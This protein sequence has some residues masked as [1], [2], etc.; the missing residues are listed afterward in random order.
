MFLSLRYTGTSWNDLEQIFPSWIWV[1]AEV[2]TM[3]TEGDKYRQAS[4]LC[5]RSFLERAQDQS[6]PLLLRHSML[7]KQGDK[8]RLY[9]TLT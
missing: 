2:D 6:Q 7:S 4:S 5:S 3:K 1:R 9:Q 8:R